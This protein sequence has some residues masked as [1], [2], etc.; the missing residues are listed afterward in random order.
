[1]ENALLEPCELQILHQLTF[2]WPGAEIAPV[3]LRNLDSCLDL[4]IQ[5][6]QIFIEAFIQIGWGF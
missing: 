5:M 3:L 6:L 4:S 2:I 1:M